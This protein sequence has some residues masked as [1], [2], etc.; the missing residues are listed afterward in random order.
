VELPPGISLQRLNAW[1]PSFGSEEQR[2]TLSGTEATPSRVLAFMK[3]ATEIDLVAHGIVSDSADTSYILLAPEQD[4]PELG[5]SEV[6]AATLQ[7]APFVVLAACQAAHTAYALHEPLSLPAAFIEA[8]ARGVLA[9][10]VEIPDLEAE[11][12]FKPVRERMRSGAPPAD[13]L[14]DERTRWLKEGK[15]ARWLDSVLLFE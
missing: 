2:L 9:A 14:R 12:F 3:N 15:G 7:G 5:I 11:A 6:R 8:G 13:A 4:G 1:T 10:T